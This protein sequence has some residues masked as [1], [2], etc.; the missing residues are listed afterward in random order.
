MVKKIKNKI[1]IAPKTW[2]DYYRL[3]NGFK[4]AGDLDKAIECFIAALRLNGNIAEI[5]NNLANA[6]VMKGA[7]KEAK[8][9]YEK[10]LEIQPSFVNA[11]NNLANLLAG[12]GNVQESIPYY[13]KAL[14]LDP[15]YANG[16]HNAGHAYTHLGNAIMARRCYEKLA[17]LK[18]ENPLFK[19]QA[20]LVCPPVVADIDIDQWL[21]DLSNRLEKYDSTINLDK[22][23][24][25]LVQSVIIPSF[26]MAY[27][28]TDNMKIKK[29]ISGLFTTTPTKIEW[30]KRIGFIVTSKHEGIFL[31]LTKGILDRWQLDDYELW[32]IGPANSIRTIQQ[33]IGNDKANYLIL[34]QS[35]TKSVQM[36]R[37]KGFSL[38]Y[39]WEIGTDPWNYFLPF[40]RLGAVQCTSWGTPESTTIPEVDYFISSE[41]IE[42]QT[43]QKY[44]TEK[45]VT[46]KNLP[47]Y[48]YRPTLPKDLKP[49]KDFGLPEDKNI[50]LCPQTLYKFHP[51]FDVAL[52]SILRRDP[53]GLLLLIAHQYPP[54]NEMLMTRFKKNMPDV[55]NRILFCPQLKRESFFNLLYLADVLLDTFYFSGGNSIYEALGLGLPVITLPSQFMRGRIAL[56]CYKK[57]NFTDCIATTVEEYVDIALRIGMDSNYRTAIRQK[58]MQC[59]GPLFEDLA[60][61]TEMQHFFEQAIKTKLTT[62]LK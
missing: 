44:Y 15:S 6:L 31:K 37:E 12:V 29:K 23:E 16:F 55:A 20:D 42:D 14:E 62:V 11:Y 52:E 61:A 49:R 32:F 46:M 17:A 5:H 43:M 1:R 25:T 7:V 19:L 28:G 39:Y 21:N 35:F 58:I 57:I 54:W 33:Q 34:D 59:C 4:T 13:E 27:Y 36:I 45:L 26:Q 56:G 10:A 9:C 22:C 41:H 38:L 3:G 48:Y 53:K 50:Y 8:Q 51:D 47:S 60:A 30:Q 40:F 18:P 2:E 24:E